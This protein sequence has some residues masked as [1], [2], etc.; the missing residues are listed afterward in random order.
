MH[1]DAFW[2]SIASDNL[3]LLYDFE[4]IL[5]SHGILPL[6]DCV[7]ALIKLAHFHELELYHFYYDPYNNFFDPTFDEL[8]VLNMLTNKNMSMIL[9]INL[10]GENFDYLGIEIFNVKCF[11]NQCCFKQAMSNFPLVLGHVKHNCENFAKFLI[12]VLQG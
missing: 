6:L 5:S 4:F 10:N 7:H 8:N 12:L 2:S 11:V 9:C 1:V 3:S